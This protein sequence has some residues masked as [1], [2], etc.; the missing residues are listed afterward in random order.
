M[1]E[2]GA[3]ILIGLM[4]LLALPAC[5]WL[6]QVWRVQNAKKWPST[7]GTIQSADIEVASTYL[8]GVLSLPVCAFSYRING[9]YY[10]GRFSLVPN[11]GSGEA[12]IQRSVGRKIRVRYNPRNPS[13]YFLPDEVMDGC[14][15]RQKMKPHLF[16][17]YP[18][19]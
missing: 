15:V 16:G 13:V 11:M 14:E 10:S 2:V 9:E 12:L 4:F 1:D 6:R 8:R 19:D 17:I 18:A 5:W 7:E 3:A